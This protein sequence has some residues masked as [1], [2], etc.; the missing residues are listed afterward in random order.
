LTQTE[1]HDFT[2]PQISENSDLA[3]FSGPEINIKLFGVTIQTIKATGFY[4]LEAQKSVSPFWKLS[5]GTEGYNTI[6]SDI[7]GLS[8]DYTLDMAIQPAEIGNANGK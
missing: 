8:A 3:V 1:N 4:L 5:I 7:L 6:K 2:N